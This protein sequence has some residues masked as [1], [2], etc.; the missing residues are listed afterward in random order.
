LYAPKSNLNLSKTHIKLLFRH[1][2]LAKSFWNITKPWHEPLQ[3]P[4]LSLEEVDVCYN[5]T[6]GWLSLEGKRE[7]EAEA[8]LSCEIPLFHLPYS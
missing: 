8:C 1:L 5:T 2:S 3:H 7:G 6:F 4:P